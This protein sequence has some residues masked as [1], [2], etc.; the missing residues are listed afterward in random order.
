[1]AITNINP[2][3]LR[4]IS[5][6][7]VHSLQSQK[8]RSNESFEG[9]LQNSIDNNVKFSKHAEERLLDRKINLSKEQIE[10]I[11]NGVKKAEEKGIKDSLI[12]MDNLTL[13]VNVKSKTV[14]TA[15]GSK[16]AR[17]NVFTNIDGAVFV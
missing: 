6:S 4:P 2:N 12:M 16:D 17:Q 15:I 7:P 1:M 14:V 10:R 13:V 5:Q 9:I 11:G 8:P 3:L